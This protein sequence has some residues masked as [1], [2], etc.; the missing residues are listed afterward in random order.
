MSDSSIAQSPF[1]SVLERI[2]LPFIGMGIPYVADIMNAVIIT[3]MFST[4]NSGLYGA[5]RMIYGL[6]KQKMFL[7][8]FPSS[9][10]KAR[11]LMRCFFPFLFPL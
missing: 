1:V 10:D 9:T 2:N 4:A 3:A 5:S 6:S 8:F 7:K 11:P